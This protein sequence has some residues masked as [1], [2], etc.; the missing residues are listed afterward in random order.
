MIQS[1]GLHLNIKTK[2]ISYALFKEEMISIIIIY[3]IRGTDV[4]SKFF[5]ICFTLPDLS[6]ENI[7]I[8][9]LFLLL[10]YGKH[11]QPVSSVSNS[12]IDLN[13]NK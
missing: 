8:Q 6:I 1:D 2:L 10:T 13:T 4:N 7:I 12:S 11:F 9:F 3:K 5:C